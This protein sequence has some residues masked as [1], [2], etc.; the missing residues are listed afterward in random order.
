MGVKTIL[1]ISHLWQYI[2]SL[3][4]KLPYTDDWELNRVFHNYSFHFQF[5]AP[6]QPFLE[7]NSF[8]PILNKLQIISNKR[9]F[10]LTCHSIL[11][12]FTKNKRVIIKNKK[13]RQLKCR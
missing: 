9:P 8:L 5:L 12:M 11:L 6:N 1:S 2:L 10:Y 3:C 4:D 7:S 13:L